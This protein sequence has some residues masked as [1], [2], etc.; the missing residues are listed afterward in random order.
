MSPM[1][2]ALKYWLVHVF[3]TAGILVLAQTSIPARFA[4][5]SWNARGWKRWSTG[6]GSVIWFLSRFSER[7]TVFKPLKWICTVA[8][9]SFCS[10]FQTPVR[11]FAFAPVPRI[12]EEIQA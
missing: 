10:S 4:D 5:T 9:D 1:P 2:L 6:G 11:S 3:G 7:V 8:S 12:G